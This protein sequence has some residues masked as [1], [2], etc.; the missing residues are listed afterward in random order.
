M[1]QTCCGIIGGIFLVV[2][3]YHLIIILFTTSK[4]EKM[5]GVRTTTLSELIQMAGELEKK[6]RYLE[7]KGE[8]VCDKPVPTPYAGVESVLYD[9]KVTQ[10]WTT[11]G[12][13]DDVD[14]S[15]VV[16]KSRGGCPFKLTDGK[17]EV[18]VLVDPYLD[19]N[20]EAENEREF[21][22]PQQLRGEHINYKNMP[23]NAYDISYEYLE[24]YLPV[25]AKA[26]FIGNVRYKDGVYHLLRGGE[27][28]LITDKPESKIIRRTLAERA[29]SIRWFFWATVI[30]ALCAVAV[31]G[32]PEGLA[33]ALRGIM[34]FIL[35]V[36]EEMD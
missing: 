32:K 29:S 15:E 25:G 1:S 28:S 2:M 35:D 23:G 3:L 12:G 26:Y 9:F 30:F 5:K 7:L 13:E 20:L 24:N 4:A 6:P 36:L 19:A 14:H 21:R 33:D 34:D 31:I 8:V 22:Q 11:P 18:T 10:Y 27:T 17:D 16:H